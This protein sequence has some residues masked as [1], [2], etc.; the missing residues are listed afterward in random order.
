MIILA[1]LIASLLAT[2]PCT[3]PRQPPRASITRAKMRALAGLVGVW[4]AQT[5]FHEKD[6]KTPEHR[7]IGTY[8][9]SWALDSSYLQWDLSLHARDNPAHTRHMMILQT[10]NP[11]SS[12]YEQTYF[13]KTSAMRVFETGTYDT[14]AREYRTAAFIPL[15]DG[16]RDEQVR[17][18]TKIG[19]DTVVYT[20]YSRHSNEPAEWNDFSAA[21]VRAGHR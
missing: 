7:E 6:G 20:H 10:Y 3:N 9:I 2:P 11:D 19:S 17:T 14:V 21:L 18:I 15:E 5:V 8:T 12:R 16:T 1:S 13:Y 4:D